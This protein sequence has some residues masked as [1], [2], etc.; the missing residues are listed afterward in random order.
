[1]AVRPHSV[2]TSA[3]MVAVVEGEEVAATLKVTAMVRVAV[4]EVSR[5][6][7]AQPPLD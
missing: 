4:G 6:R 1:M 2:A 5:R 3:P 7:V